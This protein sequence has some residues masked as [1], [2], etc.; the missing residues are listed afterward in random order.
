MSL[1]LFEDT[2]YVCKVKWNWMTSLVKE[3]QVCINF[4]YIWWQTSFVRPRENKICCAQDI[5]DC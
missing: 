1:L 3:T 5:R 4:W 2:S